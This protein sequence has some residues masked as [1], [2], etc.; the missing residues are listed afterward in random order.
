MS[1]WRRFKAKVRQRIGIGPVG[2]GAIVIG[3]YYGAWLVAGAA[4]Q[5]ARTLWP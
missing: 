3:G 1:R 4:I 5:L 2:C